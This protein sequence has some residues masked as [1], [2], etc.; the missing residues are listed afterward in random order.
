M[1]EPILKVENLK[2]YFPLKRGLLAALRGE[3]HRFVHAVD[4]VSFEIYKK[5][6]F[7]LVGESGCGKSTTGRLIVKLLEPTDGKIYLE[8][9]DVT[10]ITTKEEI[11][12]YRRKV[13]MIFQDPFASLNPRFRIF[14]VL[15]EPLLIHGIGE[16][17]AEREELVYKALEM[18]KVTP[19]EDY[20]GRFPHMLSGGQRQRVA[21]ARA[22]ILNPTF[23]VADEPV[24]MLDVSI[25]AEILEL[26]KELK[27]KMGVTYLYITHDMSTARYFADWMAVMYLGRIVEM[28]PAKK[29]IDNPLHPYT[30]AL[31]AAVPEPK[32]ERKNVIKELPIKGEVPS[33]V[34]I[35]PGCRFHPRCIY[36]QKGLCDVKQPQLIEYEHNHFAEC[37]LV[38]KY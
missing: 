29:V 26:M 4:G 33:A 30:R 20:V 1:A 3:P 7:A 9:Q 23:V 8:G 32:P 21:I 12:A 11:L 10:Q 2:K 15:E 34:N 38:G 19:P 36:A 13:Q 5:Q 6:V 17:R 14:D 27:E 37:H 35:P 24:S 18:V 22:L 28:G 31:L 25:R 16:T